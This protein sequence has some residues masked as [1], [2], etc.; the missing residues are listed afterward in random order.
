MKARRAMPFVILPIFAFLLP[1]M[2][3]LGQP[4]VP[5]YSYPTENPVSPVKGPITGMVRL[6]PGEE[7]SEPI[8][9]RLETSTGYLMSQVWTKRPGRFEFYNVACG[10]Y[11]L[12]VDV[13]GY[14]PVRKMVDHSYE[15]A[16]GLMLQ[17]I[18]DESQSAS[19]S[20]AVVSLQA[21]QVPEAAREEFEKGLKAVAEKKTERATKHFENAI[22]LHPEYDDAYVQLMLAQLQRGKYAEARRVAEQAIAQNA[23]NAR[24]H[25]VLGVALRE[26]GKPEESAAALLRSVEIK[27]DSWFSQLE[28]GRTLFALR[29]L[30]DAY[31]HLVRAHELNPDSPSVHLNLYNAHILRSDFRAAVAELDEFLKLF[32]DHPQAEPARKQRQALT[33]DSARRQ[34]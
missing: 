16:E 32:P 30:E 12:A 18:V 15:P 33:A 23:R 31:R 4:P 22:E 24:A 26:E 34:P 2:S 14:Y 21:L 19:R 5:D 10:S 3:A 1:P 27:E 9:V 17:L 29:R 7:L 6:P 20:G 25:A 8:L 28:L 11:V 13:S